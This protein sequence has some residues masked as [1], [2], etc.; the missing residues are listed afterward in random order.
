MLGALALFG[1]ASVGCAY[2]GSAGTLI[3]ARAVLGLA[4]AVLIPMSMAVLPCCS[5]TSAN[6]A[7][8]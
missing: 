6:A 7:G 4:A 3:I 5:R 1:V 2:A 8:H